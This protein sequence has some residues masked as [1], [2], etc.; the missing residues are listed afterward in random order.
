MIIKNI[1]HP[2]SYHTEKIAVMFFPLEKLKK[3]G[4]DDVVILTKKENNAFSV[5]IKAYS[6]HIEKSVLISE[7][8]DEATVLSLLLYDALSELMGFTLPWGIL[9]GVRPARL[10]HATVEKLGLQKAKEK[11]F[12]K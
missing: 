12:I 6:R 9:Y 1:N 3:D 7:N 8:S 10:M 5:K 4:D 2:Y 11:G